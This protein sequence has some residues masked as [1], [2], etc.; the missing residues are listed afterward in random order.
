MIL[1]NSILELEKKLED[2]NS[3]FKPVNEQITS[4]T[5]IDNWQFNRNLKT[6]ILLTKISMH[7]QIPSSNQEILALKDKL[8]VPCTFFDGKIHVEINGGVLTVQEET[9]EGHKYVL[10]F[11]DTTNLFYDDERYDY[12]V[13]KIIQFYI[14][15]SKKENLYSVIL[16]YENLN[17]CDIDVDLEEMGFTRHN[18][19]AE[20]FGASFMFVHETPELFDAHLPR[21]FYIYHL[22]TDEKVE[23]LVN[24]L[25]VLDEFKILNYRF[26][27][28]SNGITIKKGSNEYNLFVK[29]IENKLELDLN[30]Q[31]RFEYRSIAK[32]ELLL[33][34]TKE[35]IKEKFKD[36]FSVL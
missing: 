17:N 5:D 27:H 4:Q 35:E 30:I 15:K 21:G 24:V 13:Q 19:D 10:F 18:Q 33:G 34:S 20:K 11:S 16:Q 29:L 23:Q 3:Q 2:L 36:L 28:L 22:K 25:N 14:K 8:N 1:M 26:Y 32:N 9:I 31:D 12:I 6:K 7:L